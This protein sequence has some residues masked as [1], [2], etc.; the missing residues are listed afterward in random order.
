MISTK[1]Q[2]YLITPESFDTC[3]ELVFASGAAEMIE[4]F[5]AEAR[6]VGGRIATGWRYTIT[7]V[8]VVALAILRIG[9]VPS[10]AE[11]HRGIATLTEE[12]LAAVGMSP[13]PGGGAPGDYGAF[14]NWLT[15]TLSPLDPGSDLPARRVLNGVHRQM[16][17]ARTA[18]QCHAAEAARRR[19]LDVVNTLIAASVGDTLPDGYAGDLL[20]DETI[21]DLAGQSA[22]LGSRETKNRGA[23]YAGAYYG[24]D[25]ADNSVLDNP[26]KARQLRKTAFGIGV[27]AVSRVGGPHAL[28][29]IPPVITG[30]SIH[31]PTSGF[32]AGLAEAMGY[33]KAG[34]FDPCKETSASSRSRRPF[35]TVDMGYN[36]KDGFADLLLDQGYAPVGRYPSSWNLIWGSEGPTHTVKGVPAGPVQVSGEF[37]CPAVRGLLAKMG[38]TGKG[39]LLFRTTE[40]LEATKRAPEGDPSAFAAQDARIAAVFPYLMGVNTRPYRVQDRPGRPL[41]SEKSAAGGSGSMQVTQQLVCPAVQGRVSCPLK[42][43]SQVDPALGTPVVQPE[44]PASRYRCCSHS[45]VSVPFSDQQKKRAQWGLVPGSWEHGIYLEAARS[46]TE[47]RFSVMKNQHVTGIE[48]L[49]WSPRRQPMLYLIIGLWVAAT[50]LAIR[51]AHAARPP[52]P[53]STVRRLKE[54]EA[55]LGRPPTRIPPRT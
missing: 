11:I 10:V 43:D 55:D 34:G 23:A 1:Q 32:V 38:V 45:V 7:A 48:H 14:S 3:R 24:R 17:A 25:N 19:L 26:G 49:K 4:G 41:K 28:Y 12:Q 35:L 47:Q 33:H 46:A 42:P 21:I 2:P 30:V 29:S 27:T 44:W 8:L 40:L 37:Y 15:R 9:R 18:E 5:S 13:P 53:S 51:Q 31:R 50:N 16:L 54:V 22:G 6:G 20:A 52:K 39:N 36:V